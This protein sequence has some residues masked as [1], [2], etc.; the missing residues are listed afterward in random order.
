MRSDQLKQKERIFNDSRSPQRKTSDEMFGSNIDGFNKFFDLGRFSKQVYIVN[1]P[2]KSPKKKER[3]IMNLNFPFSSAGGIK[4]PSSRNID[5]AN[6]E[7]SN[8]SSNRAQRFSVW[9]SAFQEVIAK[10]L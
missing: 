5:P 3:K 2:P 7:N 9:N 4:M 10:S 6:S 8:K 1:K